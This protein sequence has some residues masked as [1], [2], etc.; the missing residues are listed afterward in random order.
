MVHSHLNYGLA[1][2]GNTY[3][4]YLSKLAKIQ[5]KDMRIITGSD[6][7]ENVKPLYQKCEILNLEKL[8][9]F[10]T[11]K[12]FIMIYKNDYLLILMVILTML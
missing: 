5:N 8:I 2:W 12:S 3:P 9:K 7:Q 11:A 1:I 4:A 10:E 6:W